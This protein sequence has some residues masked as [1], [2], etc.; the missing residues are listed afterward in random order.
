M[1]AI[2]RVYTIARVVQMLGVGEDLI[3][4]LSLGMDPE[5]GHLWVYGP[6][7]EQTEAFT[8]YGIECLRQLIED[9]R[10]GT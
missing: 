3:D 5:D 4:E 8:D 1:A 2:H 6:G 7:D 10:K 9:R